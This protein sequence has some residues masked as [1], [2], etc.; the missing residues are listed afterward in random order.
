MK[1]DFKSS[2][3]YAQ[4][5][6]LNS[7]KKKKMGDTFFSKINIFVLKSSEMHAKKILPP[8]F[9]EGM[10]LQIFNYEKSH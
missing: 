2:E 9:F 1:T 6:F 8:A 5:I 4:K 7:E 10:G 3:M